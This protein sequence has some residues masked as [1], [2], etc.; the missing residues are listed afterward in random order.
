[1]GASTAPAP[2]EEELSRG[3]G[4]AGV[5][6]TTCIGHAIVEARKSGASFEQHFTVRRCSAPVPRVRVR[7]LKR[8]HVVVGEFFSHPGAGAIYGPAF[9]EALSPSACR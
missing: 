2:S 5:A 8:P 4:C 9:L 6:V 7:F 1:M 3:R